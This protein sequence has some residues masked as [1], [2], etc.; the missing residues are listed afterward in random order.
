MFV[1][2]TSHAQV[3]FKADFENW[4]NNLPDGWMGSLSTI[5]PDSVVRYT[6]NPHSGTSACRLICKGT[7]IASKKIFSSQPIIIESFAQYTLS[8]WFKGQGSITLKIKN[9]NINLSIP[10]IFNPNINTNYTEWTKFSYEFEIANFSGTSELLFEFFKTKNLSDDIQI[11][12]VVLTKTVT[13]GFFLDVN[14][15]KALFLSS[16]NGTMFMDKGSKAFFE[17]PKGSSKNTIFAHNLWIGG[18][19]TSGQNIFLAAQLYNDYKKD[20]FNGPIANSYDS[21]YKLKYDTY[22]EITKSE[23]ENHRANYYINGYTMPTVISE[24]PANGNVSNGEAAQ[25]APYVDVNQ[26]NIYDPQNGDYPKIKGDKCILFILNDGANTH[27]Y[28]HGNPLKVDIIGMAYAFASNGDSALNQ[29]IFVNY[30]IYNRSTNNYKNVYLG[31][32]TDFDIGNADDDYLGYDSLQNMCY[33]Y[34]GLPIDGTGKISEYG[35]YPPAQG[36]KTLN[37]DVSKFLYFN[38]GGN[39]VTSNPEN[40]EEYYKYLKGIWKDGT[41]LTY[42]G[43]GYNLSSTVYCNYMLTGYPEDSTGW[44]EKN[45]GNASGDRRAFMSVGPKDFNIG[46][47]ITLDLAFIFARDYTGNNLSSVALLRQRAQAIQNH[48]NN[49]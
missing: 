32:F 22:W 42:G 46:E 11:D 45:N 17:V 30:E 35:T 49:G 20:F 15:I 14:D 2:F 29:T 25:L 33:G 19:D 18:A 23:V 9:G 41:P 37:T 3:V 5:S 13:R 4:T 10:S 31:S 16:G 1:G 39:P 27:S 48:Y 43:M 47:K 8:Y 44:T 26:N 40:P 24:W 21:L 6:S 7:T 36:V 28:S 38:S 12:D 34:N